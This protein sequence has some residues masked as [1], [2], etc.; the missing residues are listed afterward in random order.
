M[1]TKLLF[2]MNNLQC[3]GAEKALISLLH[4]I[5]YKRYEVDLLLFKK[6][7]VFLNIVPNEVTILNEQEE[8]RYFDGRVIDNVLKAIS[9]R[10]FDL[11]ISRIKAA[12]IFRTENNGAVCEQK[13]WKY[14]SPCLSNV[15]K[16]YDVAIGFLE[17]NPIYF[18]LEK[19][20]AKR[21]IGFIHNDYKQMGMDRTLDLPYF[22]QLDGIMTVSDS[23]ADVLRQQFPEYQQKIKVIQ[24]I[25]SKS[26]IHTLAMN[27]MPLPFQGLKLLSIGRLHR[28][29]G[30]DLALETAA[31]LKKKG[32]PF[33]WLILGEGSERENLIQLST[34]YQLE[35]EV[36]FIGIKENPY[37]YI[38]WAD[39][40]I[41]PSRFEG[42]SIAVEEAKILYKP[43]IV[44]NY[45][46]SGD[47]I[48]HGQ[49]GLIANMTAESLA[50]TILQLFA[51]ESLQHQL[52]DGLGKEKL[53]TEDEIK[54]FYQ[55]IKVG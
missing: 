21:K 15:K 47:Q 46:T 7:G 4:A 52:M 28:Q 34:K 24:N 8:F 49:T 38:R 53:G 17:K 19:A 18:C 16:E 42:K 41:Q 27:E 40:Y 32:V 1:K 20:K 35:E 11:A 43:V 2:V 48:I 36:Q 5:D 55:Y 31:L 3:G 51:D 26:T 22:Q 39:A 13:V 30:F 29:K 33:K 14:I 37:P 23:C 10:R 6:E 50:E 45:S 54:R 25:L 9:S 44:T 12:R